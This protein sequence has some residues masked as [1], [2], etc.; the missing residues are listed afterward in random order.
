M[1]ISHVAYIDTNITD[2]LVLRSLNGTVWDKTVIDESSDV[3]G[4][5]NSMAIDSHNRI[6]ISYFDQTLEALKYA[7]NTTGNWVI[8]IIDRD[9]A[10]GQ[11]SVL[12][13]DAN[14]G[15]HILYYDSSA[16][17]EN[18]LVNTQGVWMKTTIEDP[19]NAGFGSLALDSNG[20]AHVSYFDIT[21]NSLKYA[22][23]INL[24][25]APTSFAA[26][27]GNAQVNLS[28]LLPTNNGGATVTRYNIYRG[29]TI[30]N[31]TVLTTV[32]AGTYA[33]HDTDLTNGAMY[34]Y[35]VSAVNS[36]G[37]GQKATPISVIPA[38]VPGAPLTVQA[39]GV[40]TA[41]E[42][43]WNAPANGGSAIVQYRI[44]RGTDA[45]NLTFLANA[46]ASATSYRDTGLENGVAYFY[47][48]SAVNDVGVGPLASTVSATPVADDTTLI[49]VG[50]IAVVAII[51]I[52][53]VLMMRRKR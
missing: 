4:S 46:S 32:I 21:T 19:D 53:V 42:L 36:E 7:T 8:S 11:K 15:L 38:T 37:I 23:T 29:D 34:W 1:G 20:R 14:D 2:Q 52:A 9:G 25:S 33:L 30:S 51:G 10:V 48:V 47:A 39:K 43:S 24:P 13:L 16:N 28:W 49:I 31:M 5:W 26:Q 35:S 18:Y 12:R 50:T 40:N 44:L 45:T 22:V 41:V 3:L 17:K 6:H 27:R